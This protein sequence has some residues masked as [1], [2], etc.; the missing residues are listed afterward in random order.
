[1]QRCYCG[2]VIRPNISWKTW[3]I[4]E[5]VTVTGNFCCCR[6]IVAVNEA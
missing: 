6:N 3:A 5:I 2:E 4:M 1:M